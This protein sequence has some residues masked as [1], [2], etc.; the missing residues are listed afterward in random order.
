MTLITEMLFF[1]IYV[2][3]FEYKY[4]D[5]IGFDTCGFNHKSINQN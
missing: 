1:V 3:H 2:D 5:S 4:A